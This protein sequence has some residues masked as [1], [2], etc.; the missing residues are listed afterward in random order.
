[1]VSFFIPTRSLIF[2]LSKKRILHFGHDKYILKGW[3]RFIFMI[4]LSF[5]LSTFGILGWV[6][7]GILGITTLLHLILDC[8][9]PSLRKE[10]MK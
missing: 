4:F 5:M 6:S 7:I 8:K 3:G 9:Y 2:I 10:F 1:M